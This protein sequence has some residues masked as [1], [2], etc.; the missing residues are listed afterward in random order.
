MAC[1]A[2]IYNELIGGVAPP[3]G[4]KN[5]HALYGVLNAV[6]D[7][8]YNHTYDFLRRLLDCAS[9]ALESLPAAYLVHV[10]AKSGRT[11]RTPIMKRSHLRQPP[12]RDSRPNE[13]VLT[14]ALV[15]SPRGVIDLHPS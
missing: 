7:H 1:L 5:N 14:I 6:G 10:T 3:S 8:R 15:L 13:I 2:P 11:K 9:S 4:G 12:A